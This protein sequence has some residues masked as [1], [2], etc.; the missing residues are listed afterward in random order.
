MKIRS[1]NYPAKNVVA[2]SECLHLVW[3]QRLELKKETKQPAISRRQVTQSYLRWNKCQP[4]NFLP[5]KYE[6]PIHYICIHAPSEWE[7]NPSK[8]SREKGSWSCNASFLNITGAKI[9]TKGI[10]GMRFGSNPPISVLRPN[11]HPCAGQG[12]GFE[13]LMVR[14]RWLVDLNRMIIKIV[15]KIQ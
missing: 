15:S 6:L 3:P 10:W 9:S 14:I 5:R 11:K 1:K 8:I 2:S 12:C 4:F 13:L 7:L